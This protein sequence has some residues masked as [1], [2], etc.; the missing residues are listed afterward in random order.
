EVQ[1][2]YA[3]GLSEPI[4]VRIDTFGTE[5]VEKDRLYKAVLNAT[6]LR[7]AA[8]IRKFCLTDPIFSRVSCYGHFGNNASRMPWERTDLSIA[9]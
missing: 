9:I 7:P 6:D 5:K 4:S 8:I 3:I 1:L 2:S